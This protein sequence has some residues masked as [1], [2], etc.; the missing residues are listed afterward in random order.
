MH[1]RLEFPKRPRPHKSEGTPFII[2]LYES[3][4]GAYLVRHSKHDT[5]LLPDMFYAM[6]KDHFDRWAIVSRHRTLAAAVKALNRFDAETLSTPR[7]KA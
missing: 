2:R 7:G 3:K 5:G 1:K 4:C 6:K